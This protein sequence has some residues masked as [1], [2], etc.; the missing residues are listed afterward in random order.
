VEAKKK[1]EGFWGRAGAIEATGVIEGN[2]RKSMAL[3]LLSN[4]RL[5]RQLATFLPR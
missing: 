5:R 4:S 3:R 1:Q 2:S